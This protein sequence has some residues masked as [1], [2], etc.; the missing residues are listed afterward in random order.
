MTDL[1]PGEELLP[2]TLFPVG[3]AAVT[4]MSLLAAGT[5]GSAPPSVLQ[6]LEQMPMGQL[7]EPQIPDPGLGPIEGPIKSFVSALAPEALG[8]EPLSGVERYRNENPVKGLA[9]EIAGFGAGYALAGGGLAR[10]AGGAVPAFGRVLTGLGAGAAESGVLP[11]VTS[12]FAR[13]GLR[14]A[15]R[16]APLEALRVGNALAFTDSGDERLNQAVVNLAFS[17]IVGGAFGAL[18]RGRPSRITTIRGEE[19]LGQIFKEW[20]TSWA[21]QEKLTR[22]NTFKTTD[23]FLSAAEGDRQVIEDVGEK[24]LHDIEAS[25][26]A[27]NVVRKLEHGEN[28]TSLVNG[29][30]KQMRGEASKSGPFTS[31]KLRDTKLLTELP[32]VGE[33]MA[34]FLPDRWQEYVAYP[35]VFKVN[36][37]EGSKKLASL[38]KDA[39]P[40]VADGW[41]MNRELGT[42][43]LYVMAR[44]LKGGVAHNPSDYWMV[45]KTNAPRMFAR[46]ND[47]LLRTLEG[48]SWALERGP[49]IGSAWR[50]GEREVPS[51]IELRGKAKHPNMS[52]PLP[53]QGIGLARDMKPIAD[54]ILDPEAQWVGGLEDPSKLGETFK[55]AV[56]R[57][58]DDA[59]AADLEVAGTTFKNIFKSF[60]APSN[61]KFSG[62]MAAARAQLLIKE[63][64]DV[65]R[66][67]VVQ[68]TAGRLPQGF[69]RPKGS[70]AGE[71][72]SGVKREGGFYPLVDEMERRSKEGIP[73]LEQFS[74][75]VYG[76]MTLADAAAHKFDA[77]VQK[78][79]AHLRDLRLH[80][81]RDLILGTEAY[82]LKPMTM[83]SEYFLLSKGWR[84]NLRLPLYTKGEN[85]EPILIDF[86]SG[87]SRNEVMREADALIKALKA[88][89]EGFEVFWKK[90]SE[91]TGSFRKDFPAELQALG[92]E[93]DLELMN[94][95]REGH[96]VEEAIKKIRTRFVTAPAK[97]GRLEPIR[98]VNA[99]GF[100][101]GLRPLTGAEIKQ[102]VAANLWETERY[103]AEG[104]LRNKL[105]QP[106]LAR[107]GNVNP[108]ATPVT[109]AGSMM[110]DLGGEFPLM[111]SWLDRYMFQAVGKPVPGSF[112]EMVDRAS[113]QTIGVP[114][115]SITRA[116]NQAM[117]HLTFGALDVGFPVLNATTYLQTGMPEVMFVLNAPTKALQKYYTSAL[118]PTSSGAVPFSHIEPLKIASVALDDFRNAFK[119]KEIWSDV[120][121]AMDQGVISPRFV[122][123]YVGE[124]S[125]DV[126]K[127]A[128]KRGDVGIL[129][130]LKEA[131]KLPA[132][133]SEEFT[134]LHSFL[135]GRR[136]ARD[137][138]RLDGEK[139]NLF[140]K[141]FTERTM[142]NYSTA[143]RAAV[144]TGPI[145]SA[146]GMFKNW[147]AH[148]MWNMAAYAKN[149]LKTG[150]V[151][152]LLWA[153]AGT[154]A[155]G[156]LTAVPGYF[157]LDAFAKFAND[158]DAVSSIYEGMGVDGKSAPLDAIFY[159]VPS[160]FGVSLSSRAAAP[161]SDPMRDVNSMFSIATWDR[162]KAFGEATGG[163]LDTF[164]ET[165][166][167]PGESARVFDLFMKATSPR[168]IYRAHQLTAEGAL[169]SLKTGN[170]ILSDLD[171][172]QQLGYIVGLPSTQIMKAFDVQG[173]LWRRQNERKEALSIY[174][175]EYSQLLSEHDTRGIANMLRRATVSGL[176]PASVHASGVARYSN[177]NE[178]VLD[179]QFQDYLD[180]KTRRAV[181]GR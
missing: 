146:W 46:K 165:G 79:L 112:S 180:H 88:E 163:I 174:G 127:D 144:M 90:S 107:L 80:A 67:R 129:R 26:P 104:M 77:S 143:D 142:F 73:T 110:R 117:F 15:L 120:R 122:E 51:G 45:F 63:T 58:A 155:I 40:S 145:G 87:Y 154:G 27:E 83:S 152:P 109:L 162:V 78:A 167:G 113:L 76:K 23:A 61:A 1:L 95:I 74:A 16:F 39:M 136:L 139:A 47:S 7:E 105:L 62:S 148:Y 98:L 25:W 160:F 149:G 38:I 168:S 141:R 57:V 71:L 2:E 72:I 13:T 20:N 125:Q 24:L 31:Y 89:P 179:R 169:R 134:R 10:L 34:R 176:D 115:G 43:G 102:K 53:G 5:L 126:T 135:V 151:A 164:G 100:A 3:P 56:G 84:G 133:K 42:D 21:P 28:S 19:K 60:F 48:T 175:E 9:T 92:A 93:N 52:L 8:F 106:T 157:A 44:K 170:R 137:F 123:E 86:A 138:R 14:E 59:L 33:R 18:A 128:L 99:M 132:A 178:D 11:T 140:A 173:E 91:G 97:P 147:P 114:L 69:R 32:E 116:A 17:G 12:A 166:R 70:V 85:G 150:D 36:G 119:N 161:F 81:D 65:A 118:V 159:G 37:P 111:Y 4:P 172:A 35:T 103:I 66:R 181:L 94:R 54:M 30:F 82:G 96:P 177:S 156:G 158:K 75:A 22:L 131:D 171:A 6:Y 49:Q 41:Y 50:V 124:L 153:M 108:N 55:K 29:L 101:G 68:A 64:L 130:F 121:W